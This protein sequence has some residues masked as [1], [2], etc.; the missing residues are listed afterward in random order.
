MPISKVWSIEVFLTEDPGAI[1]ADA[2]LEVGGQRYRVELKA[3]VGAGVLR[4]RGVGRAG[5]G[6]RHPACGVRRW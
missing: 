2:V 1:R 6:G 3:I 4:L 5:R